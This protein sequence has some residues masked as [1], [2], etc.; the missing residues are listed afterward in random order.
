[1]SDILFG[2]SAA[3]ALRQQ[4][5]PSEQPG[6]AQG[7]Q[8]VANQR[9]DGALV[10]NRVEE[11]DRSGRLQARKEANATGRKGEE[12]KKE[13]KVEPEVLNKMVEKFNESLQKVTNLR[14]EINE[15]AGQTVVK[16]VD[17]TTKEVVR[18]LP[19]EEMVELS[20]R[21]NDLRGVLYNDEA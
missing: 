18:Q 13:E 17:P 16:V 19:T 21:M 2:G 9:R 12:E 5:R 11:S 15:D 14:F 7:Q 4:P 6:L 8:N 10:K 1:M 20:K 3:K